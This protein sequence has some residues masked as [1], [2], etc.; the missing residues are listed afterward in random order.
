M[1]PGTIWPVNV[2][3]SPGI[4]MSQMCIDETLLPSDNLTVMGLS[5]RCRF[6]RVFLS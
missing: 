3:G 5:V 2:V 4:L 1:M 6:L